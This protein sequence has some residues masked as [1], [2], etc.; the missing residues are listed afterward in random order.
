MGLS[1][2]LSPKYPKLNESRSCSA[3]TLFKRRA[4]NLIS[5][6]QGHSRLTKARSSKSTKMDNNASYPTH[7]QSLTKLQATY[8]TQMD[9]CIRIIPSDYCCSSRAALRFISI[10]SPSISLTRYIYSSFQ[11]H[12]L[13][14]RELSPMPSKQS[15]CLNSAKS[16]THLWS[17]HQNLNRPQQCQIERNTQFWE[18]LN[19]SSQTQTISSD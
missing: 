15:S 17:V 9:G 11:R 10:S 3:S 2:R 6:K 14:T 19:N 16:F 12:T 8:Q 18:E 1:H 4:K 7:H 13:S 5:K